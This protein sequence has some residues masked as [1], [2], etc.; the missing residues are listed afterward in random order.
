MTVV[1]NYEY[2]DLSVIIK[3]ARLD[4]GMVRQQYSSLLYERWRQV[5]TKNMSTVEKTWKA[6]R[7]N[8]TEATQNVLGFRKK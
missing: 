4:E 7:D 8:Y 2:S 6:I 3:V 5:A 1:A